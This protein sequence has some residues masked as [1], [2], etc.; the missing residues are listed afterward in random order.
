MNRGLAAA[1]LLCQN[2]GKGLGLPRGGLGAALRPPALFLP[3]PWAR[4]SRWPLASLHRLNHSH[5]LC[6]HAPT[7][8]HCPL[9]ARP[10]RGEQWRGH[11]AGRGTE[12]LASGSQPC[13]VLSQWPW[14][15][16]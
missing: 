4:Q 14:T 9:E 3:A 16:A 10:L 5:C 15:G 12:T 1:L 8:P 11:G 2:K 7:R 6:T 13:R